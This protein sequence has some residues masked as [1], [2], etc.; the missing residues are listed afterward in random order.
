MEAIILAGGLGTRLRSVVA[1]RPKPLALV[2]GMPFLT[3]LL[4]YLKR[5]GVKRVILSVG[6]QHELIQAEYGDAFAGVSI[7]YSVESEPLGT[8]GAVQQAMQ[9]AT[10]Q[11]VFLL[12]G[13]TLF[14]VELTQLLEKHRAFDAD[15]TIA[16]KS[17]R[18]FSRYGTVVTNGR[19]VLR[20]EEPVPRDVG[21]I[22]GG[23]YVLCKDL[24]AR[25]ELPNKFSFESD[26]LRVFAGQDRMFAETFDRYFIDIGIPDDYA[27]A[28]HEFP[29]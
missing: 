26:Y 18:H 21:E 19:R 2:A 24:L 23:V 9:F 27:R 5:Q 16:L 6:F 22:N 12:N 7:V 3:H 28:Q 20:F 15:V 25:H 13:D 4:H 8:G 14:E 10:E 29:R 17:M 11:D 1:D